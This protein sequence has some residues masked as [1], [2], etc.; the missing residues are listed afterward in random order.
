M[1]VSRQANAVEISLYRALQV[2]IDYFIKPFIK[3]TYSLIIGKE[4]PQEQKQPQ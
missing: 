3:L 1:E 4:T 2:A